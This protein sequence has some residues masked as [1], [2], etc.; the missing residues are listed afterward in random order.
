MYMLLEWV[1]RLSA[2]SSALFGP[3]GDEAHIVILSSFLGGA[4]DE[5]RYTIVRFP[6]SRKSATVPRTVAFRWFEP[7][8]S[9]KKKTSQKAG[10]SFWS[11]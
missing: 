7:R 11:G 3:A 1:T 8:T 5:A 9:K 6:S 4:G 10:L 2:K